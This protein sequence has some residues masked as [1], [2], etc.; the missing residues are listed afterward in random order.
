MPQASFEFSRHYELPT[1]EF[2]TKIL[3]TPRNSV[4]TNLDRLIILIFGENT[5]Q[6]LY[7][8]EK[9]RLMMKIYEE[10]IINVGKCEK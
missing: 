8:K 5:P 3:H 6:T 10:S 2:P 9:R 7:L 1:F 4:R